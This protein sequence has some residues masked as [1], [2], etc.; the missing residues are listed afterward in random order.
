MLASVICKL[1]FCLVKLCIGGSKQIA[2]SSAIK[3]FVVLSLSYILSINIFIVLSLSYVASFTVIVVLCNFCLLPAE[4][5]DG[6][7]NAQ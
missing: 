5:Y 1:F 2:V 7:I 6:D 4:L 3:I